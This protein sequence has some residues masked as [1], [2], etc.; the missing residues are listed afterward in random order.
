MHFHPIKTLTQHARGIA[1]GFLAALLL[2]ACA[3]APVAPTESL[4]DARSA[5]ENA[6][7][8]EARQYAAAELE[9]AHA[10]LK[11]AEEAVSTERM[12]DAERLALQSRVSAELATA[13]TEAA[14]ATAINRE[15]ERSAEALREEMRR[16]G[17]QQ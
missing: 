10:Q 3:S 12:T 16:Q 15:M 4:N 11:S 1:G 14:K 13:R 5:I 7:Q 8:A 2:S 6:E 9:A 17:D